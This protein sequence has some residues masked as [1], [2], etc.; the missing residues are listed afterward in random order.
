MGAH[1]GGVYGDVR[2]CPRACG[3]HTHGRCHRATPGQQGGCTPAC[4][5]LGHVQA[6]RRLARSPRACEYA[7]AVGART[8]WPRAFVSRTNTMVHSLPL[9][10]ASSR[11]LSAC[12]SGQPPRSFPALDS[13]LGRRSSR[14]RRA[15]SAAALRASNSSRRTTSPLPRML[16][17]GG[18]GSRCWGAAGRGARLGRGRRSAWLA[19]RAT[20]RPPALPSAA[21]AARAWASS[22]APHPSST[23]CRASS[24]F[25][26]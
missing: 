8:S 4:A 23:R 11:S 1:A 20:L 26:R 2:A 24:T 15:A 12:S 9:R 21:R 14:A 6:R 7:C 3:A 5:R 25:S 18:R 22:G 10:T 13:C 16:H 19:R 17:G